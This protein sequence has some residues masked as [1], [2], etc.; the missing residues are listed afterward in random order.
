MGRHG[1][2]NH[3]H[4]LTLIMRQSIFKIMIKHSSLPENIDRLLPKAAAYLNS[5]RAVI[6]AYLFGSISRGNRGPLSDV[7]IA[8]F[9]KKTVKPFKMQLEILGNLNAILKTDEVDLV[10]LN[11]APPSL[12]MKILQT[13]KILVDKDP[14]FRHAYESLAM[15]EGMDFSIFESALLHRKFSIG[16]PSAHFQKNR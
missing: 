4:N 1:Q 5:H 13:K 12:R 7:D 15:R 9:L 14:A 10:I 6:F 3:E 11:T 2:R 16:R 8:V